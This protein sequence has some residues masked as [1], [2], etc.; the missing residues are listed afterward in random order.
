MSE[1]EVSE[2]DVAVVVLNYN[3]EEYTRRC[4]R[5]VFERSGGASPSFNIVVVDNAS[6]SFDPD[7]LRLEFPDIEVRVSGS[8]LG[9]G[10]ACNLGALNSRSRYLYFLNNDTLFLNNVLHEMCRCLDSCPEIS[11]CGARQ[12]SGDM[13]TVRS[14]RKPPRILGR[15]LLD[16]SSCRRPAGPVDDPVEV[17][18][19]SGS[20]LFIRA[21]IFREVGG[22][23]ERIFLY[24]EEDD[25]AVRV[26]RKGGKL[27]L[28]PRAHLQH[29]HGKSSPARLSVFMEDAA[30][31]VYYYEKH[32]GRAIAHVARLRLSAS[33][34]ARLLKACFRS[35]VGRDPGKLVRLYARLLL[36]AFAGFPRTVL[37]R[38]RERWHAGAGMIERQDKGMQV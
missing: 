21:D 4:L 28:V 36:W 6:R 24:H 11:V 33:Y 23:D 16:S 25:L 10:G 9:F 19:L 31:L 15:P 27:A 17:E 34:L 7:S 20:N 3:T 13:R 30:S 8:N 14:T 38:N 35:L 12:F 29:F 22:F 2:T 1:A 18:G 26:R 5:S 37:E 32:A